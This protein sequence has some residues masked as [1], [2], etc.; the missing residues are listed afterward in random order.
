MIGIILSLCFMY[1][2]FLF[3][4]KGLAVRRRR[5][6]SHVV[7]VNGIRGKSTVSR[8]IAA[9]LAAGGYPVFCKTTGTVP[10][11]IGPDGMEQELRRRG[12]AN[13]KE[14]L[15]VLGLAAKSGAEYLVV[16]CM[17]IAPAYQYVTQHQ[18][19][20][21]DIGVITNVRLDHT[22][23]MGHTLEKIAQSLANTIPRK[24]LLFTSDEA[25]FPFFKNQAEKLGSQALLALPEEDM[26]YGSSEFP[27][28]TALAL[29]VCM[30][31]GV[32]RTKAL[33]G[34][35]TYRRDPYS[36]SYHQLSGGAFFVNGFSVNDTQSTEIVYRSLEK[37]QLLEGKR[38]TLLIN[39][40]ADRPERTGQMAVLAASLC[41]DSIWLIG[42]GS[43]LFKMKYQKNTGHISRFK[44]AGALPL[45]LLGAGDALLAFGNIAGVGQEL[46]ARVEKEGCRLV[47]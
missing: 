17:A 18:M 7:H 5:T 45:D 46:I 16:E 43:R 30:H 29:A 34:I 26:L 3:T 22:D 19:L 8:M 40:R 4:E 35:R 47:L 21:A 12:K 20:Q 14:Q 2:A 13:I 38:I 36:L 42:S 25:F 23:A 31:L 1:F 27:E 39:T 6:F 11:Y 33:E 28:N 41:P 44:S 9:G 37:R 32:E 24:G 15:A 10:A